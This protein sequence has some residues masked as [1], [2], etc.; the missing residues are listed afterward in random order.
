LIKHPHR[1]RLLNEE[2][3]FWLRPVRRSYRHL[4]SYLMMCEVL[5]TRNGVTSGLLFYISQLIL[6]IMFR[7]SGSDR[8]LIQSRTPELIGMCQYWHSQTL[9]RETLSCASDCH[10]QGEHFSFAS[11]AKHSLHVSHRVQLLLL[12]KHKYCCPVETYNECSNATARQALMHSRSGLSTETTGQRRTV[13]RDRSRLRVDA[14][15][16][17]NQE[18]PFVAL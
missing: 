15:I 16:S 4:S 8:C 14:L 3:S 7:C 5:S 2:K 1:C 6:S 18:H 9:D 13:R 17:K 11:F 10:D 12:V